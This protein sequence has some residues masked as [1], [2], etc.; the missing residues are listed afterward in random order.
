MGAEVLTWDVWWV[1][2]TAAALVPLA[3]L[4]GMKKPKLGRWQGALFLLAYI[5]YTALTW[6]GL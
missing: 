4:G 3:L 1:L 5:S 2:G 6:T